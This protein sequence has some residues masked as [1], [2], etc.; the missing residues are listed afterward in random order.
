MS[1]FAARSQ[2]E[3]DGHQVGTEEPV[4]APHLKTRAFFRG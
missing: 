1:L 3:P 4:S 2:A